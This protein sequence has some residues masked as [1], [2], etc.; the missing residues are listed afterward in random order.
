[1][2]NKKLIIPF[3]VLA[4]LVASR[5]IPHPPNFT[6][7]IAIAVMCSYFFKNKYISLSVLFLSMFLSDVFI[8]FYQNM[9]VVYLSLLL[10]V[11][12][13]SIVKNKITSKNLFIFCFI[14][15]LI[16]F[17][18]SNFGVWAFGGMY[19]KNFDGLIYCYFLAIPFFTNTFLSTVFFSYVALFSYNGCYKKFT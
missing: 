2:L 14:G 7:V 16:F 18:V 19:E 5:L 9:Y 17:L 15:S 13:F 12:F 3:S 11:Y 6:P 4:L 10:I 8:G 1:M